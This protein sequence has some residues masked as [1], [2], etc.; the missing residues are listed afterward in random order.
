MRDFGSS[1]GIVGNPFVSR[2]RFNED[3]LELFRPKVQEILSF[4]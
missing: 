1:L 2:V 4:E 3:D